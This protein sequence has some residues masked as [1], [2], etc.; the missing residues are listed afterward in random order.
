MQLDQSTKKLLDRGE[1]LTRLFIQKNGR[2]Y[3]LSE[4]VFLLVCHTDGIFA[5]V[6]IGVLTSKKDD[7]LAYLKAKLPEISKKIDVTGD[8]DGDDRNA[9]VEN[10]F[11]FFKTQ[12]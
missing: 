7:L 11:N 1:K 10:A 8:F 4:E 6:E 3:S 9:V 5:N 12:V 2:T